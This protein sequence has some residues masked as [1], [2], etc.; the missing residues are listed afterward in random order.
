MEMV[1]TLLALY[2]MFR[3]I[4][5]IEK[6]TAYQLKSRSFYKTLS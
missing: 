4:R 6:K 3:I 2:I 1:L 5:E